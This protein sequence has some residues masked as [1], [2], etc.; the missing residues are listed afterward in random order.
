LIEAGSFIATLQKRQGLVVSCP[1]EI[2]YRNRWIDAAQL[3][4]LAVP[5]AKNA[6]GRYLQNLLVDHTA[7]Q[8]Q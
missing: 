6:Y 5:L 7:W 3:Q 4:Q 1:E 2:A 8:S